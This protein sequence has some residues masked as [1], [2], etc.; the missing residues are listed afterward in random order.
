MFAPVENEDETHKHAAEVG[1]VGDVAGAEESFEHFDDGVAYDEPLGFD[2]HEEV[3]VDVFIGECHAESQQ[4]AVDGSRGSDSDTPSGNQQVDE[5]CTDAADKVV[6]YK[7]AGSPVVLHG[8]A[9]HPQG[10]HVEEEM[11]PSAVHE[12]VAKWLPK[13]ETSGTEGIQG[14]HVGDAIHTHPFECQ[15]K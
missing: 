2:G 4:K 11:V 15:L 6:E 5:S 8:G 10:K 13:M 3:E 12:H 7:S 9:E 1:E 14:Q